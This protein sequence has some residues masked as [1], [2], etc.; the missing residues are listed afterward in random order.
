MMVRSVGAE[1]LRNSYTEREDIQTVFTDVMQRN[2]ELLDIGVG[3]SNDRAVFDSGDPDFSNWFATQRGWYISAMA[4]KPEVIVT[5]PSIS[6]VTGDI[7]IILA[8]HIGNIGGL[9]TILEL[10]VNTQ[11]LTDVVSQVELPE[12]GYCFLADKS[13]TI[14]AHTDTSYTPTATK[15][16]N[17]SENE[18]YNGLLSL[19]ESSNNIIKLKDSDGISRYF[20]ASNVTSPNWT[21]YMAI[22]ES[23]ILQPYFA[24]LPIVLVAF[25]AITL[26]TGFIA[27]RK[28]KQL[29]SFSLR[30]ILSGIDDLT[31]GD[32][33]FRSRSND[34]QKDKK[35]D[36]TAQLY[37]NFSFL[38][39]TIRVLIESM[40]QMAQKH[41][42]GEYDYRIDES[43]YTGVFYDI[44][45]GV[46]EMTH[47]YVTD[48]HELLM[49]LSSYGEGNFSANVRQ[50]PGKL[51]E[52]NR[53][54]ESL[55]MHFENISGEINN[56]AQ[57]AIRGN[58]DFQA[59]EMNLRG[60]WLEM[61]SGLNNFVTAVSAP[62]KEA[63]GTL[64][65][66][67]AGNFSVQMKGDYQGDFLLI[68]NSINNT[69]TNI[70]SYIE[71]IAEVLLQL[72]DNNL[73][74]EIK[75]EYVGSFTI[76]KD[77]IN[78][79]IKTLN[80]VIGDIANSSKQVMTGA[81]SISESSMT[82]AEGTS[83]QASAVEE[84]N[85]TINV[86]NESTARNAGDAKNAEALSMHSKSSAAKGDEDIKKMVVSMDGIKESSN[87]ITQIIKV[88]EDIAF[89]TNLLA[90][91]AAVEAARAG[92]HGKGFAVVAEE[93]RNLAS[94]CQTA[95]K[96]TSELIEES[97]EKVNE[98][99]EI[100]AR[101]AE[102]LRAILDDVG[103]VADIITGIAAA[104]KTQ[105]E[106]ISQVTDSIHRITEVVSHNSATSEESASAS[107]Q[108][109]SQSEVMMGLVSVFKIK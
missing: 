61:V 7:L 40:E 85:K 93:V 76:I 53:I 49:V 86:I 70:H 44:V 23:V 54:V 25:I 37:N 64:Q 75:R 41:R 89:Q 18:I 63:A 99:T 83:E 42:D 92:E 106:S 62:L 103:K 84:L 15:F 59:N 16:F 32:A 94:R 71:E 81:R 88:I 26:L 20:I 82:L 31:K 22:P 38:V 55:R 10:A 67:S 80:S 69:V 4:A 58:L 29:V 27:G 95:A 96:E 57:N 47:M 52:G 8:Q 6:G 109:S 73:N 104:S 28:G 107:Q 14:I 12:G 2:S 68:K 91:N 102:G 105:S 36:S 97:I 46:N 56:L 3:Y 72:S 24:S 51:G 9:E 74:Q 5:P 78:N 77:S 35:I 48:F 11:Y 108:L 43:G 1:F 17:M 30:R 98:G 100:A 21:L 79:I 39:E 90:L 50:Y 45:R 65:E 33:S 19:Q 34:G 66:M 101:T 60:K 87:K 13:G